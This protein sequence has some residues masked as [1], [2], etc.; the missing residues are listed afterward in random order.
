MDIHYCANCNKEI[1]GTIPILMN[2]ISCCSFECSLKTIKSTT[3]QKT[4]NTKPESVN[5]TN[6]DIMNNVTIKK[7]TTVNASEITAIGSKFV[8]NQE[9]GKMEQ[10]QTKFPCVICGEYTYTQFRKSKQDTK[11]YYCSKHLPI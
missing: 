9:T 6:L 5:N 3:K 8:W 2:G 4:N 10:V 11:Q 1:R 7:G